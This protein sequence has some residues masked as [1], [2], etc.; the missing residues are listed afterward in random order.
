MIKSCAVGLGI[1]AAWVLGFIFIVPALADVLYAGSSLKGTGQPFN[2]DAVASLGWAVLIYVVA[3]GIV[4]PIAVWAS[5]RA[6]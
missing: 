2:P 5:R 3:T 4:I 6:G 1:A